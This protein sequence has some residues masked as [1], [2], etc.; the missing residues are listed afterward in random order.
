MTAGTRPR[1]FKI[2]RHR[3]GSFEWKYVMAP[4]ARDAL[5]MHGEEECAAIYWCYVCIAEQDTWAKASANMLLT[6]LPTEPLASTPNWRGME[7][8]RDG[9]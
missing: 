5:K 3:D 1:R 6:F 8:W 9:R 2:M 7:Q 4:N